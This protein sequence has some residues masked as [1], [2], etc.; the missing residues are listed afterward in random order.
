MNFFLDTTL[1][2]EDP[3]LQKLYNQLLIKITEKNGFTIY[4]SEVV[5]Q[6]VRNHYEKSLSEQIKKLKDSLNE[7]NSSPLSA[8]INAPI[9]TKENYLRTFDDY[10]KDLEDEGIIEIVGYDNDL[11][12]ELIRRSIKGSSHC[13]G[14]QARIS[15]CCNL[16]ILCKDCRR[17]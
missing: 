3:F 12:P 5:L 17:T 4:I 13:T 10:Y 15:R 1:F 8:Q 16:A 9:P 11:L 6:E 2:H 7:L 14:D